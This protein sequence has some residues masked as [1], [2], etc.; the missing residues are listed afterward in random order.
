MP[1]TYFRFRQFTVHQERTA[2]KVCTDACLFGAWIASE[3]RNEKLERVLDIGAGT[4]LLSLMIAQHSDATMDAVEIDV[5]AYLQAVDNFERSPWSARMKVHHC[6]VQQYDPGLKY[7]LVISNPPFYE[8]SLRSPDSKKNIA[9]HST[10]LDAMELFESVKRLLAPAGRVALLI[11]YSRV[12]TVEKIIASNALFIEKKI[13]VQ[14]QKNT[15]LSG[16]C[17]C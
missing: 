11:P 1:N 15:H 3:I 17:I 12:G 16:A 14:K 9:M 4:G 2:M 10:H 5:N 8:Q 6:A 13:A 7:D